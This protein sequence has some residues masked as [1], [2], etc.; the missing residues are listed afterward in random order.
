MEQ[1]ME[2][3]NFGFKLLVDSKA[4]KVVFA[5]CGKDYIVFLFTILKLPIACFIGQPSSTPNRFLDNDGGYVK[6]L[7]VYMVTDNLSVTPLSMISGLSK[8]TDIES[9]A[10]FEVKTALEFLEASVQSKTVLSEAFLKGHQFED[11]AFI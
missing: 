4:H 7:I 5:E 6:G 8:L 10:E 2:T 1:V 11:L 3:T 9:T